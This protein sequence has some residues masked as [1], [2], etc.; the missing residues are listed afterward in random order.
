MHLIRM[1]V[2]P[3]QARGV[4]K[5]GGN[6]LFY[7]LSA[8]TNDSS[9]LSI[10][11]TACV[12]YAAS[13][14]TSL[15]TRIST[16]AA[17]IC[18]YFAECVH[19]ANDNKPEFPAAGLTESLMPHTQAMWAAAFYSQKGEAEQVDV[20]DVSLCGESTCPR[21]ENHSAFV[22]LSLSDNVTYAYT[23]MITIVS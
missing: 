9:C 20:I 10:A 8:K 2:A 17:V 16:D 21:V 4:H 22:S 23:K 14:P 19:S 13:I 1:S 7:D 12:E 11:W 6:L 18:C 5:G 15:V 3:S